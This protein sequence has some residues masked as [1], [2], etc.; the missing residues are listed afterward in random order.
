DWLFPAF[1]HLPQLTRSC[2]VIRFFAVT[3]FGVVD[4]LLAFARRSVVWIQSQH[5]V[6]PFHCQIVPAR[7]IKTVGLGQ[8]LFHLLDLLD[9]GWAHC[10]VEVTGLP[11][12]RVEFLSWTTLGIVAVT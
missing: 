5:L 4:F 11:Q 8:Q 9:K 7:L 2:F 10:F 1:F 12:M 3:I 6:I